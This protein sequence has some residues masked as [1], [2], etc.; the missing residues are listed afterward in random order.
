MLSNHFPVLLLLPLLP[1]ETCYLNSV[2]HYLIGVVILA[3]I[4]YLYFL[5]IHFNLYTRNY[6]SRFMLSKNT[7]LYF[8]HISLGKFGLNYVEPLGTHPLH[9]ATSPLM[10]CDRASFVQRCK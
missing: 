1:P 10:L 7:S 9:K 4:I 2:L 6:G 5:K 3:V 8:T